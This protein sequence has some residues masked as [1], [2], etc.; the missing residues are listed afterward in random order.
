[1]VLTEQKLT[2]QIT[3]L[4]VIIVCHLDTTI[5]TAANTHHRECFY[6]LTPKGTCTYHKYF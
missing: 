5:L 6:K 2:V 3:N 4:N 1:M